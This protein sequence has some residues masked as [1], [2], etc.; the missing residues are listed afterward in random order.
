MS[1][2]YVMAAFKVDQSKSI[3][4]RKYKTLDGISEGVRFALS[5][6]ADYISIRRVK[7]EEGEVR[8]A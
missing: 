7:V 4:Y 3:V 6:R 1:E 2:Q 5:M 8:R